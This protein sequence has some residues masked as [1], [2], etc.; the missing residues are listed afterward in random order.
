MMKTIHSQAGFLNL[1]AIDILSPIILCCVCVVVL[2]TVKCKSYSI[3]ISITPSPSY[4]N[5]KYF[6]SLPNVPWR[7]KSLLVV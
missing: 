5:H 6:Q 7:E 3:D 2:C 1:C 4:D